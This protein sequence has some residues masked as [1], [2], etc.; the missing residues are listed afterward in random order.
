[1]FFCRFSRVAQ[2]A[3]PQGRPLP[4]VETLIRLGRQRRLRCHRRCR[5]E[6]CHRCRR[7]RRRSHRSQEPG[8]QHHRR[9]R[10]RRWHRQSK[11]GR[12]V[13]AQPKLIGRRLQGEHLRSTSAPVAVSRGVA[14]G[15]RVARCERCR[16]LSLSISSRRYSM[17]R[18]CCLCVFHISCDTYICHSLRQDP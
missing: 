9:H 1:M 15:C 16:Y 11:D 6:H 18:V 13:E 14:R 3:A 10:A 8:A 17:L 2:R 4:P 7:C 12:R 5:P